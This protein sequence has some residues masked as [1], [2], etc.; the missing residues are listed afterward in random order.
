M[1]S[2][3][4]PFLLVC[5]AS[6]PS[7]SLAQA[8]EVVTTIQHEDMKAALSE[9]IQLLDVRTEAEFKA[10]HIQGAVNVD[11]MQA[12]KIESYAENLDKN[13]AVYLY[14]HSGGRSRAVSLRLKSLGF[15]KIYDYSGGYSE[16]SRQSAQ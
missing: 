2:L 8:S 3:L 5:F 4:I 15:T 14:C 6:M 7:Y 11:A 1:K 12:N 13:K 16:W 10:G 9:T